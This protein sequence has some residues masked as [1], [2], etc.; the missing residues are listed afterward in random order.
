MSWCSRELWKAREIL[1]NCVRNDADRVRLDHIRMTAQVEREA[2]ES[3]RVE[4]LADAEI[5]ALC[6]T[7]AVHEQQSGPAVLGRRRHQQLA[8]KALAIDGD[9]DVDHGAGGDPPRTRLYR[10]SGPASCPT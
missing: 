6:I 1:Y 3:S 5:A 10:T 2:Y 8:A 9:L 7:P 4:L